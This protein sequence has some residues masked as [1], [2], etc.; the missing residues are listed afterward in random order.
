MRISEDRASQLH[1]LLV[2]LPFIHHYAPSGQEKLQ[3]LPVEFFLGLDV[4]Q[5]SGSHFNEL[6]DGDRLRKELRVRQRYRGVVRSCQNQARYT[7][8]SEVGSQVGSTASDIALRIRA[9]QHSEDRPRLL[10]M[11]GAVRRR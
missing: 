9:L 1:S 7:N 4:R 6:R 3:D 11:C 5:M 8:Q 10:R 2:P